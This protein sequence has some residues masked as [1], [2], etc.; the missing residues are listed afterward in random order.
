[1]HPNLL[2]EIP[3]LGIWE[4]DCSCVSQICFW[5]LRISFTKNVSYDHACFDD[6][7][8]SLTTRDSELY[9]YQ[10]IGFLYFHIVIVVIC[11]V[12]DMMIGENLDK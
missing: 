9:L 5:Y 12:L 3:V 2:M 7:S 6:V 1:M 8:N 11:F 4:L 10:M